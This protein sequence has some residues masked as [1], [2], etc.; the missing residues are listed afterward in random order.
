MSTTTDEELGERQEAEHRARIKK[1]IRERNR[2]FMKKSP[3]DRRAAIAKDVL[4]LLAAEKIR[5][6]SVYM[7]Q[8]MPRLRTQYAVFPGDRGETLTPAVRKLRERDLSEVLFA[9]GQCAVCGIG[10]LFVAAV[11][12]LDSFPVAGCNLFTREVAVGRDVIV[13]YLKP[14]FSSDQLDRIEWWFELNV[15]RVPRMP[16]WWQLL[17]KPD[18]LGRIMRNIHRNGGDFKPSEMRKDGP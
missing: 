5:A 15:A 3:G 7:S 13:S 1:N 9:D 10:S 18:R 11:A 2:R 4:R 8:D 12:K 14:H 17:E 6:E 16:E